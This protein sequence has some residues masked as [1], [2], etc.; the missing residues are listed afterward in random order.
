M[1]KLELLFNS[2]FK[3]SVITTLKENF[4]NNNEHYLNT[5]DDYIATKIVK[6]MP[7]NV[8]ISSSK[9]SKRQ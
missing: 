7:H 6:K 5:Q 3:E 9:E 8:N 1:N 2:Q 4:G